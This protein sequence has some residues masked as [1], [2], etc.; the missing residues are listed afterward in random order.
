MW[1]IP[2]VL[3]GLLLGGVWIGAALALTGVVILY[4]FGGGYSSLVAIPVATW[5]TLFNFP[6]VAIP[7]YIF[8][9]EAFVFSGLAGKSYTAVS[10]LFE[11]F[12]G[13]LLLTN[14]AICGM[15]GAVLGSSMATAATVSSIAYPELSKRGYNRTALVGNLAGAGTLGSFVPPS[16]GLIIYGAWVEVSVGGCFMAAVFPALVTVGLFMLYIMISCIVRPGLVP[17]GSG[18]RVPLSRAL[19][20]TKGVWPILIL[21]FSIM[22]II[23]LGIATPTEAGGVASVITIIMA[24]IFGNFNFKAFFNALITTARIC[25]MLFF[26]IVGA[27]IF[28]IS[29][30]VIGL[31]RQVVVFI[32]EAG[33]SPIAIILL[34]YLLYLILGCFIDFISMLVM[35]LPF[36]F[37]IVTNLGYDPFWFGTV[38]VI[39]GE[40]GLLTPPVGMNLY[41]LQ[42][43]TLGKVSLGEIAKG[44]LPYFFMLGVTLG[45]ITLFPELC[46]W[47]PTVM[48]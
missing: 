14:V 18:E 32:G 42:G 47:L 13:K 27:V 41:V 44:A 24:L 19:I 39:T 43:I 22:G 25:G 35:T 33:L 11:R 31:P 23:Y 2:L 8:L 46:T 37:P 9:G 40:I 10:P 16:I 34:V 20:A 28:S 36:I 1:I 17:A 29:V 45:L 7:L 12:P 30:S 38:L 15:F 21:I 5:N 4:F 26:I 6:L 48:R 3:G